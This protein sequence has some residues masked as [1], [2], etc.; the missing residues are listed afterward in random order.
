MVELLGGVL[1]PLSPVLLTNVAV[2]AAGVSRSRSVTS[3]V[4]DQSR[5]VLAQV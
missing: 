5:P 3:L 1:S 4:D 2:G